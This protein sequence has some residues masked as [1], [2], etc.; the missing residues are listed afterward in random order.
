MFFTSFKNEVSETQCVYLSAVLA[1]V[2]LLWVG[3]AAH[4]LVLAHSSH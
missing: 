2:L 3:C 1:A 4:T